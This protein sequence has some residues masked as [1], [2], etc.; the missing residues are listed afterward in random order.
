M[1]VARLCR[2]T[3]AFPAPPPPLPPPASLKLRTQFTCTVARRVSSD[4]SP[5]DAST[6]PLAPLE[7]TAPVADRS[8]SLCHCVRHASQVGWA[9]DLEAL[10]LQA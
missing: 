9:D 8:R 3:D 10:N 4:I 2:V 1:F 7:A 5:R 6:A